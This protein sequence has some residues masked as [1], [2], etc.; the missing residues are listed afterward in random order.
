MRGLSSSTKGSLVMDGVLVVDKPTGL[1]SHDVV[2]HVRR[3]LDTRRIGH[4]G[5]LDPMATGVL[6]LVIG[7]ATRLAPLLSRGRKVY[8]GV[9]R[10]GVATDTYD[11]T[12]SVTSGT[13]DDGDHDQPAIDMVAVEAASHTFIG[14]IIQQ[15]PPFSAKKI[16]GVRAYKLARRRQRVETRAVAVTVHAFEIVSLWGNRLR[17]RVICDPGFYMRALAHDLGEML[18]CGGCLESLRRECSSTFNL[19]QSVPLASI[20]DERRSA[21]EHIVPLTRLLPE[22]PGVVLT[23]H[24]R[25]RAV[26][27]NNVSQADVLSTD[28]TWRPAE[29][30]TESDK[31]K[32][33]DREGSLIGIAETNTRSFLHPTIV[34]V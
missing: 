25:R 4:I 33:Y 26:H 1:T 27:G 32:L 3:A 5:T 19:N 18:G 15:P 9:I 29:A 10:L 12:G 23:D 16:R 22:L 34:L 8:D 2:A 20:E 30:T 24:G 17:C 14:H 11:I 31:V 13:L 7:R 21:A 6:P 28:G